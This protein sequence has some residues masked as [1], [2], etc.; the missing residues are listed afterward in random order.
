[1]HPKEAGQTNG[2]VDSFEKPN[3]NYFPLWISTKLT[4]EWSRAVEDRSR[5]HL[6]DNEITHE[7]HDVNIS[8]P[9]KHV[10]VFILVFR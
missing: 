7:M 4:C 6:L 8:N 1:M 5:F 3:L 9:S 2:V 10:G